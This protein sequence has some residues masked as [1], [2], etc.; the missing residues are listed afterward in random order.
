MCARFAY[1]QAFADRTV[2]PPGKNLYGRLVGKTVN[3]DDDGSQGMPPGRFGLIG[4]FPIER[5]EL[6]DH[7]G[8]DVCRDVY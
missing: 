7:A 5:P 4:A 6:S 8:A 1:R 2:P 3:S